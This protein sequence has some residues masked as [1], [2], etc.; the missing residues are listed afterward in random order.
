[1]LFS[2]QKSSETKK[3]SYSAMLYFDAP[4]VQ[5]NQGTIKELMLEF[6]QKEIKKM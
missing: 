3:E 4:N 1:M 5:L 6:I 2:F